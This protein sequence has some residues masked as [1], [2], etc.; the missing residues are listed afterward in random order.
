MQGGIRRQ[1]MLSALGAFEHRFEGDHG[2][3]PEGLDPSP[4]Q[5]GQMAA[6]PQGG[7]EPP[8]ARSQPRLEL[9][10]CRFQPLGFLSRLRERVV[11]LDLLGDGIGEVRRG[12][13]K[14][15]S[16]MSGTAIG[17]GLAPGFAPAGVEPKYD[18][19]YGRT[20]WFEHWA[21]EH[22]AVRERVG[23]SSGFSTN[24]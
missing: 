4:A 5:K 22:R 11:G 15:V 1:Q 13:H 3:I 16:P 8:L 10:D 23:R 20:A 6:G 7:D 14:V 12:G 9:G 2:E 19:G 18:Y 17:T 24:C 21:S